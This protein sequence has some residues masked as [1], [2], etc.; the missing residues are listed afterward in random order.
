MIC[1]GI[2]TEQNRSEKYDN[3]K[4]DTEVNCVGKKYQTLTMHLLITNKKYYL[5]T[6]KSQK[7]M[8]K[9]VKLYSNYCIS[10]LIWIIIF[11]N[12]CHWNLFNWCL[13]WILIQYD[14]WSRKDLFLD[15]RL[16]VNSGLN[17][18]DAEMWSEDFYSK[19]LAL[20]FM[21]S[22]NHCL[23]KYHPKHYSEEQITRI[24]PHF[25]VQ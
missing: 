25:S 20:N 3:R 16:E 21:I 22:L 6:R 4:E 5:W 2:Y 23:F 7:R 1:R 14:K 9:Y 19:T 13:N 24:H 10:G 17:F 8:F 18:W 11:N 15:K 12:Q